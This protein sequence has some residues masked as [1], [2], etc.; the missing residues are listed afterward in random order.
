MECKCFALV[1]QTNKSG[2][3]RAG[4]GNV[5]MR[6]GPFQ[7]PVRTTSP[8]SLINLINKTITEQKKNLMVTSSSKAQTFICM[9]RYHSDHTTY[10]HSVFVDLLKLYRAHSTELFTIHKRTRDKQ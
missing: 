10:W 8:K 7:S 5:M 4:M 1:L 9:I 6:W 3:C 2:V